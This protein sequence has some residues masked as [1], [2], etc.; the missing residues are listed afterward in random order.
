MGRRRFRPIWL[1]V[2]SGFASFSFSGGAIAAEKVQ[3]SSSSGL[4]ELTTDWT[5]DEYAQ[6]DALNGIVSF[7]P[8]P[9]ARACSR[10]RFVQT[11]RA[12]N[13]KAENYN[14]ARQLAP[15]NEIRGRTG[16]FVDTDNSRC[17][18]GTS[19]SPFYNDSWPETSD[20]AQEGSATPAGRQMARMADYVRGWTAFS[21]VELEACAVCEGTNHVYGCV[22]WG[23]KWDLVGPKEA[24]RPRMRAAPTSSWKEAMFAFNAFYDGGDEAPWSAA[25]RSKRLSLAGGPTES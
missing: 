25:S 19:C 8:G 5:F 24:L 11:A 21:R 16:F 14:W 20:Y 10:I 1:Y 18:A 15:R 7:T 12:L 4:F 23:G 3:W 13:T 6:L 2:L 22:Q 17:E 9:D